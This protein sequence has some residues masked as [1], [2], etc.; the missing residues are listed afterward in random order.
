MALAKVT[1]TLDE[2]TVAKLAEAAKR[3]SK[4]KS[5]VVREAIEDYYAKSDRLSEE[6]RLRMIRALRELMAKPP[7]STRSGSRVAGASCFA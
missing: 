5:Q 3:V 1:F 7:A 2:G 6:E 4:P